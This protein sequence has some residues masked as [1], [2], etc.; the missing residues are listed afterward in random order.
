[1][2]SPD[3]LRNYLKQKPV[4]LDLGNDRILPR[5]LAQDG[6]SIYIHNI[7]ADI[8]GGHMNIND[9]QDLLSLLQPKPE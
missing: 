5:Y 1:M 4:Q 9:I 3:Q 6:T 2:N 7:L 8:R